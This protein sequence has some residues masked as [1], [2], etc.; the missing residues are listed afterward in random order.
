MY[1]N[2]DEQ[3][4]FR[5]YLLP[6]VYELNQLKENNITMDIE[7]QEYKFK[8][9]ITHCSVDLPAKSKIQET[10]QFGGYDACTYCEIPGELV[11]ITKNSNGGKS[12]KGKKKQS[13]IQEESSECV[14]YVEG[15]DEYPLRDETKTLENMILASSSSK[16]EAVDGIKGKNDLLIF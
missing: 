15:N 3:L 2:S 7:S 6:L 8:P 5:D 4:N 13:K 14:R 1:T 11:K 12:R 9:V 16:K 10:K